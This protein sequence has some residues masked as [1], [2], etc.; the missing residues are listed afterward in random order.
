M[1]L[2]SSNAMAFPLPR[3]LLFTERALDV[4]S[5]A[6]I[7]AIC[8]HEIGHVAE[9]RGVALS[10]IVPVLYV[11]LLIAAMPWLRRGEPI[12]WI[13]F[14][15]GAVLLI[16]AAPLLAQR[17]ERRADAA[18]L[19][20]E[21]VPGVYA[22]ALEKMGRDNLTPAVMPG[23]AGSH[24]H[25][26]DRLL[27]SERP[28]TYPRPAPPSAGRPAFVLLLGL[29]PAIAIFVG[30][31]TARDRAKDENALVRSLALLGGDADELGRLGW[32]RSEAEDWA[33]AATL[34]SA[35]AALRP[36]DVYYAADAAFHWSRIARCPEA[37]AHLQMARQ[38]LAA[39]PSERRERAVQSSA[40]WV[41]AMCPAPR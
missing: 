23:R 10:R 4:M 22:A 11:Y 40:G 29:A 28:P 5:D 38:R 21:E 15:L 30:V 33:G 8:A 13:G 34:L 2:L 3:V 39:R 18:G 16:T 26:Y 24:P 7:A 25:L 20:H 12:H 6:E 35:A 17:F 14:A 36:D 9:P 37:R 41:A 31:A 19:A 1:G 32:L 27:S